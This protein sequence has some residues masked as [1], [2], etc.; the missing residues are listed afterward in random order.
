MSNYP[1]ED[2]IAR[3]KREEL[4]A[5]QMIGQLLLVLREHEQ[6]LRELARPPAPPAKPPTEQRR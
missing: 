6:R 2:L 1:L 4:S 3:W 5:E